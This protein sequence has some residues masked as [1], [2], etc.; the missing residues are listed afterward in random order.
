[1]VSVSGIEYARDVVENRVVA[2][3]WVRL[4]CKRF[5]DDL[6]SPKYY[7]DESKYKMIVKFCSVLKHYTSGAAGKSFI[8]RLGKIL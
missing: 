3:R 8:W 5:L 7:F 1:M 6:E 2:C 4:A